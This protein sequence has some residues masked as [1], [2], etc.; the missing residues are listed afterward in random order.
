MSPILRYSTPYSEPWVAWTMLLLLL[1]LLLSDFLQKGIILG[2]FRS[3]TAAKDRESLFSEVTKTTIGNVLMFVYEIGIFA[4]T[5]YMLLAG[6]DFSF[7]KYGLIVLSICAF[8]VIKYLAMRLVVY[9][10]LDRQMLAPIMMHTENLNIVISTL[11]YPIVLF[12]LFAPFVGKIAVIIMLIVIA[13]LAIS[14]WFLKAFGL[15][16]TNLFAGFYIFLYL[17]T[18]EI[19]PIVGLISLVSYLLI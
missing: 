16:F 13:I 7:E 10:F 5:I 9:V 8:Y 3:I 19:I 17:C 15:F 14:I 1:L 18:L 11:L 4:M 12:A 2:S 6:N